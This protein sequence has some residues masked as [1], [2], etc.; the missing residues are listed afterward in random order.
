MAED[1]V[2][3]Y[4]GPW[5]CMYQ[6]VETD[7]LSGKIRSSTVDIRTVLRKEEDQEAGV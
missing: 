7:F 6:I 3:V 2:R 4:Q 1:K 5:P